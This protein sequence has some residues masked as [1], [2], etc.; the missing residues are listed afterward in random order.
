MNTIIS[1]SL[2]APRTKTKGVAVRLAAIGLAMTAASMLSAPAAYAQNMGNP[3]F[4]FGQMMQHMGGPCC[5]RHRYYDHGYRR[6]AEYSHRTASRRSAHRSA[7]AHS[8]TPAGAKTDAAIE[9]TPAATE[10][11]GAAVVVKPATV[12]VGAALRPASP[13]VVIVQPAPTKPEVAKTTF[14]APKPAAPPAVSPPA[15][16]PATPS[17]ASVAPSQPPAAKPAASGPGGGSFY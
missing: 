13:P 11:N 4:I 6:H 15:S 17:Q 12:D 3:F 5:Y 10:T 8:G 16:P 9:A 2:M 14:E 7:V 1:S